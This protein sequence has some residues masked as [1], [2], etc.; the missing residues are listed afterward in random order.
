M[1]K[2]MRTLREPDGFLARRILY[3]SKGQSRATIQARKARSGSGLIVRLRTRC[4]SG[5]NFD[6]DLI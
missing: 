6:H 1:N 4:R 5:L 3:S 2:A